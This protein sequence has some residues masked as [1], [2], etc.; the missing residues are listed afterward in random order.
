MTK[1]NRS[2]PRFRKMSQT[3]AYKLFI[4]S[5]K[6]F[7]SPATVG[8]HKTQMDQIITSETEYMEDVTPDMLRNVL[9]NF[10]KTHDDGGAW[11]VYSSMR[12]FYNWYWD[13]YELEIKNPIK[14][15][16]CKKPSIAP[17]LFYQFPFLSHLLFPF[18]KQVYALRYLYILAMAYF[19]SSNVH[20]FHFLF[21]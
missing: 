16:T 2:K 15:V 5:R 13:E 21:Y 20:I 10:R 6:S 8:I 3:E 1:I 18:A 17:I 9:T 7:C 19:L 12:A 11:R 14:K 4:E